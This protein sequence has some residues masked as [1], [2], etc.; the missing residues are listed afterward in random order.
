MKWLHGRTSGV[1]GAADNA[2]VSALPSPGMAVNVSDGIGWMSNGDGDGIVWWN[3]NEAVNKGKLQI[4]IDS[5]DGVLNRIDRIIVEWKTTNYVDLPE[6]KVLKGTASSNA[7]AP[8]L[9]NNSTLRQISL[10]KISIAAG[11]TAITASMITD[12]R[13]DPEVCGIVTERVQVDTSVIQNQVSGVLG[14]TK[15]KTAALLKS[16]EKELAELEA[17]TAVELKKLLF[18][19]VTIPV[20]AFVADT[21]Y[22]DYGFRAAVSLEGVISSMVPEVVFDVA[23]AASGD[24]APVAE[25]YAGGVYIYASSTPQNDIT[26]PTI[27]CWRGA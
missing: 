17:G 1:F 25:S 13:L 20:S 4:Q 18:T 9:T 15:S 8:S 2:A 27:I 11:T 12:E 21:T 6:I 24:F 16:I 3:D 14:E 22:Q 7:K 5:A 19:N 23:T 10:A 26:I